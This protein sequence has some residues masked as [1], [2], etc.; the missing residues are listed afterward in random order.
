MERYVCAA[1]DVHVA[2]E[3]S[4]LMVTHV[5]LTA[6]L[7]EGETLQSAFALQLPAVPRLRAAQ[8]GGVLNSVIIPALVI[9]GSVKFFVF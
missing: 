2:R 3:A 4:F 6:N 9:L 5:F 7:C 8:R 1:H